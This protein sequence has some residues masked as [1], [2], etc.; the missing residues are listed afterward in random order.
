VIRIS[1]FSATR[2]EGRPKHL[3]R[4]RPSRTARGCF[5]SA[6]RIS[7]VVQTSSGGPPSES[8]D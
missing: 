4:S 8:A 3:P 5:T 6:P 2:L 1:A 7:L